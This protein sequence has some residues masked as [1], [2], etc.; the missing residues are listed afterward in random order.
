MGRCGSICPPPIPGPPKRRFS[1]SRFRFRTRTRTGS[2]MAGPVPG[3]R[4]WSRSGAGCV[5][6]AGCVDRS[7]ITGYV[8]RTGVPGPEIDPEEIGSDRV[9]R[10]VIAAMPGYMSLPP[11]D[12]DPK[13]CPDSPNPTTLAPLVFRPG[14]RR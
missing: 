4:G 12:S 14:M 5:V 7:G 1:G 3:R 6:C 8:E 9:G 2:G 11:P 13:S 10:S